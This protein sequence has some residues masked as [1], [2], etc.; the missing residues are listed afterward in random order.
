MATTPMGALALRPSDGFRPFAAARS[1]TVPSPSI[2]SLATG[3]SVSSTTN[4]WKGPS[5]NQSRHNPLDRA[6]RI[7]R[8]MACPPPRPSAAAIEGGASEHAYARR[9]LGEIRTRP[10]ASRALF[11]HWFPP[12]PSERTRIT[13]PFPAVSRGAGRPLPVAGPVSSEGGRAGALQ[14]AVARLAFNPRVAMWKR[15][16]GHACSPSKPPPPCIR[17]QYSWK[18]AATRAAAAESPFPFR[19]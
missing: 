8:P 10:R 19:P 2:Q 15:S 1:S 13:P 6:A 5:M 17:Q 18:G 7:G 16:R 4:R 9:S 12:R 11:S 3:R 14:V